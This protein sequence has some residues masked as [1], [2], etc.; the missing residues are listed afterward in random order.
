MSNVKRGVFIHAGALVYN[1][2]VTP[3]AYTIPWVIPELYTMVFEYQMSLLPNHD[4][5]TIMEKTI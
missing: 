5:T 2:N 3:S 4:S 1:F